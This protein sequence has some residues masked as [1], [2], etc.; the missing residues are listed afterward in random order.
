MTSPYLEPDQPVTV[1]VAEKPWGT[2]YRLKAYPLE[3]RDEFQFISDLTV[4][5]KKAL[6]ELGACP[7]IIP[8]IEQK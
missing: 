5:G 4:R 1:V 6:S 2:H 3:N 8:A 7:A